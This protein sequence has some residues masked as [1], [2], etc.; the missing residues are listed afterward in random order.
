VQSINTQVKTIK[1][2]EQTQIQKALEESEH[3]VLQQ[4]L[5]RSEEEE[6]KKVMELSIKEQGN[7]FSRGV[8]EALAHGF[9]IEQ[10]FEAESLVGENTEMI[11]SYLI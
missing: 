3:L 8:N 7:G 4:S 9:S 5:V 11:M 10:A 1:S 6:L 2:L